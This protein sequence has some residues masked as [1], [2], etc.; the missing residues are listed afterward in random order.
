MG[1]P[2]PL[3][4]PTVHSDTRSNMADRINDRELITI[5]RPDETL[6]L[7]ATQ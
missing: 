2:P 6:A 3:L 7:Q 1:R 4:P 5:A